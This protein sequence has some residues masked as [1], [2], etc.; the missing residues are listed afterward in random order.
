MRAKVTIVYSLQ[1][2]ALQLYQITSGTV[3]RKP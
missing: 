2:S 3:N 1:S